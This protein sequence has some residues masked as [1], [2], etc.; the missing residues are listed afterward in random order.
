[1]THLF[2][3]LSHLMP[4]FKNY[5]TFV[6]LLYSFHADPINREKSEDFLPVFKPVN[7]YVRVIQ[8]RAQIFCIPTSVVQ[9]IMP[10]A[11]CTENQ[12]WGLCSMTLLW[13][14]RVFLKPCA[15]TYKQP[16]LH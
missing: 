8:K 2:L 14:K 11:K 9:T 1:M 3:M 10:R 4:L 5:K 15:D 13:K 6:F 7:I 16:E 12:A